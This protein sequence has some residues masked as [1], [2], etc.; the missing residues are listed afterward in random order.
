M[1]IPNFVKEPMIKLIS[2]TRDIL[3]YIDNLNLF[4]FYFNGI[5]YHLSNRLTRIRYASLKTND[6]NYIEGGGENAIRKT[7][8]VLGCL[9]FVNL[10]VQSVKVVWKTYNNKTICDKTIHKTQTHQHMSTNSIDEHTRQDR[11]CP[12][13]LDIR[14]DTSATPCGHL[15]CW[16]CIM[17]CI[18]IHPECPICRHHVTPSRIV[19]LQN[20]V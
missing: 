1:N 3:S 17:K 16:Y 9:T 12:L 19:Y 20:Y 2:K 11:K 4:A 10:C 15:F 18:S 14:K 13:C 6:T 8:K 7:F 5:Y